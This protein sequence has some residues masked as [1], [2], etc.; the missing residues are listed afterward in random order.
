MPPLLEGSEAR[1]ITQMECPLNERKQGKEG[2]CPLAPLP[3]AQNKNQGAK[4]QPP[5]EEPCVLSENFHAESNRR[6]DMSISGVN[7]RRQPK[8]S[9][10]VHRTCCR[11]WDIPCVRAPGRWARNRKGGTLLPLATAGDSS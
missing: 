5:A 4:G 2:A 6:Y 10:G 1:S 9:V 3:P 11:L 8:K 7:P